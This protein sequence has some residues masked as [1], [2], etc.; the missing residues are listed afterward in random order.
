MR[1]VATIWY[2]ITNGEDSGVPNKWWPLLSMHK[3]S[4]LL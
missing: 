2:E 3:A 1:E 4:T